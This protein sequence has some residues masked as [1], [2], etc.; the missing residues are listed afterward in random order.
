MFWWGST[1][2]T[3]Q[4]SEVVELAVQNAKVEG[5]PSARSSSTT[6]KVIARG[7]NAVTRPLDPTAHAEVV[8]NRRA[9]RGLGQFRV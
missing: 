2:E 6:A 3:A 4:L 5:G 9:C 8:A 1:S 7:S